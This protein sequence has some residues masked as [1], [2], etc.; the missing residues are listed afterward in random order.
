[1]IWRLC[2]Y[3]NLFYLSGLAADLLMCRTKRGI[4]DVR[5]Y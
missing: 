2:E 5:L 4:N 1:M 3:N